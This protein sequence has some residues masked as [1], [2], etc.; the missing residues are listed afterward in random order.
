[1]STYKFVG[2]TV[3]PTAGAEGGRK[4][5]GFFCED[6]VHLSANHLLCNKTN[7]PEL[8]GSKQVPHYYLLAHSLLGLP[9]GQCLAGGGGVLLVSWGCSS[10][11]D[12][13]DWVV[14]G[15]LSHLSDGW[16]V[17]CPPSSWHFA[18]T[19]NRLRWEV[20]RFGSRA[21]K[22]ETKGGGCRL[23]LGT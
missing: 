14:L 5:L 18:K 3:Q 20:A 1:M 4:H 15:G 12:P 7:H 2:D 22:S 21:L 17:R 8:H 9:P 6:L 23:G 19:A 16:Q 13:L 10:S 11:A